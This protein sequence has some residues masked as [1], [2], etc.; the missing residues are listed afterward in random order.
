MSPLA[1]SMIMDA[2]STGAAIATAIW[3]PE[4][5]STATRVAAERL[6]SAPEINPAATRAGPPVDKNTREA[7]KENSTPVPVAPDSTTLD[8]T[9]LFAPRRASTTP[10]VIVAAH[11]GTA[12]DTATGSPDTAD[13]T[14]A[15]AQGVDGSTC[16]TMAGAMLSPSSKENHMRDVDGSA[17]SPKPGINTI[18]GAALAQPSPMAR[19]SN[20]LR[21]TSSA[22]LCN[23]PT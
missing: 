18:A 1:I 10:P 19:R 21:A 9:G 23:N 15:K 4:E 2:A 5:I 6:K 22:T 17:R 20:P 16:A 7:N 8:S 11:S 12:A 3:I 13:L 14:S